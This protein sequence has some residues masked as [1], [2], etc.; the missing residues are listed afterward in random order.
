[1]LKSFLAAVLVSTSVKR[2]GVSRMRDLFYL[3]VFRE[4]GGHFVIF[5]ALTAEGL[6][7]DSGERPISNDLLNK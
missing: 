2:V 3:H 7:M 5:L 4:G 1:M 6:F